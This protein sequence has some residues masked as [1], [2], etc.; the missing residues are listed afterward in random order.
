MP[1]GPRNKKQPKSRLTVPEKSRRAASSA[2]GLFVFAKCDSIGQMTAPYVPPGPPEPR[3]VIPGI[4]YK[5][6]G[7]IFIILLMVWLWRTYTHLP[8]AQPL[9]YPAEYLFA[10]PSFPRIR[11]PIA[12]QFLSSRRRSSF[13]LLVL[14]LPL[15]RPLSRRSFIFSRSAKSGDMRRAF[16]TRPAYSLRENR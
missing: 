13:R 15:S 7:V 12:R 11:L 5:V 16:P 1:E 4:V 14:T 2:A 10:V 6:V 3:P 9:G 8:P